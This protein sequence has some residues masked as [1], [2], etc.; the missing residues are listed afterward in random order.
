[1]P[2]SEIHQPALDRTSSPA[3][4]VRLIVIG[5]AGLATVLTPAD[6]Q[7]SPGGSGYAVSASAAALIGGMVGLV[8]QVGSDLDLTGLQDLGVDMEGVQTL[9]GTSAKLRI[10]QFADGTRAFSSDLGVAT[11]VRPDSFPGSYLHTSHI[12]LGTAPPEQQLTWMRFLRSRMCK[13]KISA[14]MF[15]HYVSEF[16][17]ASREVC[18]RADLIFMNEA[19][20]EGLYRDS[21]MAPP[22]SPLILKRGPNGASIITNG[23]SQD[24]SA[25]AARVVDPTGGGEILAGVFL[26]L[27]AIGYPDTPALQ[28]AVQAA[29]VCV[30]EFGV[31][32]PRLMRELK[33]INNELRPR[34]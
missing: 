26:A 14:D 31:S 11:A 23:Q 13:A 9:P 15:E 3:S 19:E 7:T 27:R 10:R 25:P 34:L 16:P 17:D 30:E 21:Q 20:H 12:H 22:R 2:G 33:E 4:S 29:A 18:D 6:E 5:H 1:M 32:G 8:A 28:Y 24:V